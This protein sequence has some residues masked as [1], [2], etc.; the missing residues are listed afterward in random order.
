DF[1]PGGSLAVNDGDKIVPIVNTIIDKFDNVI[2]TQDWHPESHVSFAANNPGKKVNDLIELNGSPQVMWPVHCTQNSKGAEFVD[3]LDTEKITKVIK[4]GTDKNVDSYSGFYDND[5]K[6][7]TGLND[8]LK[9]K[10]IDEIYVTGLATDYCV[11]YTVIDALNLGLKVNLVADACRGVNLNPDDSVNAI[12]DME[13]A[14]AN[15][16]TSQDL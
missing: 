14:G 9:E 5:H 4:K 13:K 15:I 3:S 2:A 12:K 7:S 10:N 6:N 8:Y 1:C 11:K 16:I